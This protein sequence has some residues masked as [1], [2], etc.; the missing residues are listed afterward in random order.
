MSQPSEPHCAAAAAPFDQSLAD[1]LIARLRADIATKSVRREGH[2]ASSSADAKTDVE[3]A[4]ESEAATPEAPPQVIPPRQL[5]TCLR[6]AATFRTEEAFDQLHA[7]GA[8]AIL[9]GLG[10]DDLDIALPVMKAIWPEQ[11]CK[12]LAPSV[13]DGAI[14]KL[15]GE[16]FTRE[17]N[18][19]LDLATP[20]IVLQPLETTLP[21]HFKHPGI[22]CLT[23]APISADILLAFLAV[24]DRMPEDVPAFREAL[25]EPSLLARL[26]TVQVALALRFASGIDIAEQLTALTGPAGEGPRLDKGFGDGPA[27]QIARRLVADLGAWRR[28]EI[29]WSDCSH[30][31]LVY[32]PPGTGKTWLA[33][34]MANSAGI[35]YVEGSFA[36]WQSAGH[37]GDMLREMRRTFALARRAAPAILILDEI[38]AAGSRSGDDRHNLNYRTQVINAFLGEMNALATVPGLIVVG[39][40]NH[41]DRLDPAITRAG[42]FDVKVEMPMPDAGAILAVLRLQFGQ[43]FPDDDLK[44]LARQAVGH[45]LASIDAAIRATRSEARHAGKPLDISML[46]EQLRLPP[47][48]DDRDVL[49]RYAVHEAGHTVVSAALRLGT[50]QRMSIS[51]N[52][53]E[54]ASRPVIGHGILSEIEAEICHDLAGRAA[55]TLIF[56]DA[57]AGAGG[58]ASSDLSQATRRALAIETAWGLGDLGPLWLPAPETV[59]L[60][61]DKLRTRVRTRLDAAQERA[62]NILAAQR[63]NLLGLA[64]ALLEKRSMTAAEILPWVHAVQGTLSPKDDPCTHGGSQ[65]AA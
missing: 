48:E 9:C 25:P 57:S 19:Y 36:E 58:P 13:S 65:D 1:I 44:R 29:G 37:L 14:S 55:E 31:L 12:L 51:R 40:C 43:D 4:G 61:D 42:R 8:F 22:P 53:G 38:D 35:A 11:G 18:R 26:D 52:G 30:S 5:L 54:V 7:P 41:P 16:R 21:D 24:T 33:R 39:A 23:Y 59:L 63:A 32:G 34:A 6:L 2:A 3:F 20:V 56:G 45:S 50:I 15:A 49:W 64:E 17:A 60:T 10:V 46:R 62:G 47:E 28:R 27:V